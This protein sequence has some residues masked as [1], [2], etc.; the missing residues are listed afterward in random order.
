MIKFFVIEEERNRKKILGLHKFVA[1]KTLFLLFFSFKEN[2]VQVHAN[3][4]YSKTLIGAKRNEK[5]PSDVKED[6]IRRKVL[7]TYADATCP[8]I[9]VSNFYIDRL[10]FP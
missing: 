8:L 6:K 5:L 1:F 7:I 10:V 3:T 9:F 2:V 4:R